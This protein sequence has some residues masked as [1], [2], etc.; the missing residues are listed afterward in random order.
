M[1]FYFLN[2]LK[3][4]FTLRPMDLANQSFLF[5]VLAAAAFFVLGVVIVIFTRRTAKQ[6][7]IGVKG[8]QKLA[9]WC[10]AWSFLSL[11]WLFFVYERINLFGAP[12]WFLVGILGAL[13]WLGLIVKYMFWTVPKLR[14]KVRFMEEKEKYLPRKK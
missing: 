14:A 13:I 1:K 11:V 4:W 8:E 5:F 12:F 3:Y 6:D 7:S 2:S 9:V 10:L